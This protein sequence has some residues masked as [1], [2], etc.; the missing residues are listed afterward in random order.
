MRLKPALIMLGV[1]AIVIGAL[2]IF[3]A[4]YEGRTT[5][6]LAV[7]KDEILFP[8]LTADRVV[9]VEMVSPAL[10][11]QPLVL[12]RIG[13]RKWRMERP[14]DALASEKRVSELL[15]GLVA[16]R[17]ARGYPAR[18]FVEYELDEPT[19]KVS[20][21]TEEGF[22][23]TMEFGAKV[24]DVAEMGDPEHVDQYTLDVRGG[25]KK[26]ALQRYARRDGQ[27]RVLI[28]AD[29]VCRKLDVSAAAFREGALLF[30]ESADGVAPISPDEVVRAAITVREADAARVICFVRKNGRWRL[31]APV[32][33]RA[34]SGMIDSILNELL[35]LSASE[36]GGYIDD[37]PSDPA[38]Y[39]LSPPSVEV[40]LEAGGGK[41]TKH[42]LRFGFAPDETSGLVYAQ[43]SS[44]E[45]VILVDRSIVESRLKADLESFRDRRLVAFSP[46]DTRSVKI[47]Y[48]SG[49]SELVL[50]RRPEDSTRW[51]IAAPVR[52]RADTAVVEALVTKIAD[53]RVEQGG[54]VAEVAAADASLAK[55]GLDR[56]RLTVSLISAASRTETFHLGDSPA[57][58][59]NVLYARNA[60]EPSVVL[61]PKGIAADLSP[62]PTSLRSRALLEGF[63]RWSAHEVEI[64]CG[65]KRVHVQKE[66]RLQWR[67]VEPKGFKVEYA[68]PNDFL[69]VVEELEVL[70]WPADEPPDYA[71]FGLDK[72]TAVL[73]VRTGNERADGFDEDAAQTAP[74]TQTFIVHFGRRTADG[75]RCYARLASE[76]NVYEVKA[77]VLDRMQRGYLLFRDKLVLSFDTDKVQSLQI[78]GGRADYAAQRA[79]K[80]SWTLSSP[81]LGI[82]DA[83]GVK[84]VLEALDGLR[85]KELIA[86]KDT[87]NPVYGLNPGGRPFRRVIVE[88]GTEG[89]QP[90]ETRTLLVGEFV[91]DKT[92]RDRYAVVLEDG[93]VFVMSEEDVNNLDGE[94]CP[95]QAVNVV[96][97]E[98]EGV[99]VEHRDGSRVEVVRVPAG[100]RIASHR[101]TTADVGKVE[102]FIEEAGWVTAAGYVAY[103][104]RRLDDY[105]LAKSLLT[106][107]IQR[108]GKMPVVLQIGDS[109]KPR[110]GKED[111]KMH[112]ATAAGL[113]AVFLVSEKKVQ[114]LQKHVEDLIRR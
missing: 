14:A 17:A 112:Y 19:H 91:P 23:I 62:D 83:A 6:E 95:A 101:D 27:N 50:E 71:P 49:R 18:S 41:P 75:A 94:L 69:R 26:A 64:A 108:K 81:L 87:G 84:A 30:H 37:Q 96:K 1:F 44:R 21:T 86:E 100:W 43:S 74:E 109:A 107:T 111:E 82:A 3:V 15:E 47:S 103:D 57:D 89:D 102:A 92:V 51:R 61:V 58:N 34:D 20:V 85:A 67:F 40:E 25:T 72:S 46:V 80:T 98:I 24:A 56:P 66:D 36:E 10:G 105:G 22:G 90:H 63:D 5:D 60:D 39:G 4:E 76:P 93:I 110:P 32:D 78:E 59:Q 88:L 70:A 38:R 2:A 79:S 55:Y 68:A 35:A 16:M 8:G 31:E 53:L 54:F 99:T 11:K 104:T 52:G 33:A 13:A 45:S 28:V 65:E 97:G 7:L 106:L 42:V 12:K 77:D 48:G 114:A 73:T 29:D 9:R 113:P